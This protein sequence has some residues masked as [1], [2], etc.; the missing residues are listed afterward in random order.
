MAN[1]MG[2]LGPRCA[3]PDA[4]RSTDPHRP[5]VAVVASCT[6][7]T[8]AYV[9]ATLI[10][11]LL[12]RHDD[13]DSHSEH[14][15]GGF[16]P[17]PEGM[18]SSFPSALKILAFLGTAYA[19]GAA[20]LAATGLRA[21][22]LS[23]APHAPYALSSAAAHPWRLSAQRSAAHLR[24][25]ARFA[26]ADAMLF[27]LVV[28]PALLAAMTEP[29]AV[30]EAITTGDAPSPRR[31]SGGGGRSRPSTSPAHSALDFAR[32]VEACEDR[33][34]GLAL[35]LL[36]LAAMFTVL[37]LHAAAVVWRYADTFRDDWGSASPSAGGG[38]GWTRLPAA[39]TSAGCLLDNIAEVEE[40]EEMDGDLERG[41]VKRA[42]TAP[43]ALPS[44]FR[45]P[46]APSPRRSPFATS[47]A[48]RRST[49]PARHTHPYTTTEPSSPTSTRVSLDRT[50]D[51]GSGRVLVL[52]SP[53]DAERFA[54]TSP[55]H[56]RSRSRSGR[57]FS[58]PSTT[59][60]PSL[61][62]Y[63]PPPSY[64][65]NPPRWIEGRPVG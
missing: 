38:Y 41:S 42:S 34:P 25:F 39:A 56:S 28:I 33:A 32:S 27:G 21:V 20:L 10:P 40:P 37:R 29:H 30:C 8:Y 26:L 59:P 52:M 1:A 60:R 54:A 11:T 50:P 44:T 62:G 36:A 22:V 23:P 19:A 51:D 2:V 55:S 16:V 65:P 49:L 45:V 64:S 3:A 63:R 17:M 48:A 31:A 6:F 24:L 14:R 7:I 12:R 13:E 46:G 47:T 61:D 5:S 43:A 18:H 58:A 9:V 57:A 4:A 53:E 35:T 15:L